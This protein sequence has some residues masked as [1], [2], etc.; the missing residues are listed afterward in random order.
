MANF[1]QLERGVVGSMYFDSDKNVGFKCLRFIPPHQK[2]CYG[3]CRFCVGVYDW[4]KR[5]GVRSNM[6][7]KIVVDRIKRY[8]GFEDGVISAKLLARVLL[9]YRYE[10]YCVKRHC[11]LCEGYKHIVC[12][13]VII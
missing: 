1:C 12:D 2:V 9:S 11:W 10:C 3:F 6:R 13:E 7:F 4:R 8:G 5:I